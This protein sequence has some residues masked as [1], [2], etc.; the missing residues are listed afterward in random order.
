MCRTGEVIREVNREV[1]SLWLD[2][3]GLILDRLGLI[4]DRLGIHR[5]FRLD[6]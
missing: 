3:L 6:R 2:R 5:S 4:L 1:M